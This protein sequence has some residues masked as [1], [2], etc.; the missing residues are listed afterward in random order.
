[1]RIEHIDMN[2]VPADGGDGED[3]IPTKKSRRGQASG[4]RSRAPSRFGSPE[5]ER[6]MMER[7]AV[8]AG[9]W[10]P[11]PEEDGERQVASTAGSSNVV[12]A[13]DTDEDEDTTKRNEDERKKRDSARAAWEANHVRGETRGEV[14]EWGGSSSNS[15]GRGWTSQHVNNNNKKRQGGSRSSQKKEA[16]SS[17]SGIFCANGHNMVVG[18]NAAM[19]SSWNMTDATCTLCGDNYPLGRIY[20]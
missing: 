18:A 8:G 19:T 14:D 2:D 3:N 7:Q 16:S 5:P 13:I 9:R 17:D 4:A 12:I 6:C 10:S 20:W 11:E 15:G 1:M